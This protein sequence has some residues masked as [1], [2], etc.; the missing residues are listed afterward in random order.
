MPEL[1]GKE[2]NLTMYHDLILATE[3]QWQHKEEED[4]MIFDT[5]GKMTG[6]RRQC[7]NMDVTQQNDRKLVLQTIIGRLCEY[8]NI[9]QETC[10]TN[11]YLRKSNCQVM[12]RHGAA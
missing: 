12:M 8:F 9:D 6:T 3:F 4:G 1:F 7:H 10:Q 11:L 2:Q 5:E